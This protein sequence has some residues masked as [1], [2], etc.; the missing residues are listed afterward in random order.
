[1]SV[2]ENVKEKTTDIYRKYVEQIQKL[3]EKAIQARAWQ[4]ATIISFNGYEIAITVNPNGVA[5]LRFVSPNKRN[6]FVI[7]NADALEALIEAGKWLEQNKQKVNVLLSALGVKT[8]KS[9]QT[10][11]FEL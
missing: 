11:E 1:M 8:S 3:K 4:N 5:F 7:A 6:S 2:K 10:G 9:A